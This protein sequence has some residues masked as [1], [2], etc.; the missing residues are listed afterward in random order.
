MYKGSTKTLLK[1]KESTSQKRLST[2]EG[3]KESCFLKQ[4]FL[5]DALNQGSETQSV[6]RGE[7]II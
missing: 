4:H 1:F 5:E 7:S 6:S 3:F 2:T